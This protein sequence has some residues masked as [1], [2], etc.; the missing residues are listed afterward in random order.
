MDNQTNTILKKDVNYKSKRFLE[1]DFFKGIA[2]IMMVI[3]H[4][5]YLCYFMNIRYYNIN[6]GILNFLAKAAHYT[7]ILVV[8]INL[9][10]INQ[11]YKAAY[12][13]DEYRNIQFG[14]QFKRG[15]FLI[16][17]GMI[18]SILSYL[19]FENM[20]IKFGILHFVGVSVILSQLIVNSKLLTA[21]VLITVLGL[22]YSFKKWKHQLFYKCLSFPM[23][24]FVS[25]VTNVK[26]NSLDHFSIIPYF[27][28]ICLG[29]LFGHILYK[30][31]N[32]RTFINENII[33][34]LKKNKVINV[35]SLLGKNSLF[36][37]F[38]HFIV[39]YFVLSFFKKIN[40]YI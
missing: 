40:N 24:C 23:T 29:I 12:G 13:E 2:V 38:L 18:M 11:K 31:G 9:A 25:G 14:K 37:Y 27:A 28:I 10:V 16:G 8:G 21:L 7:F 30:K 4:F 20:Y 15:M 33:D 6:G 35:I 34:D 39:F 32:T 3:F 1:L 22:N 26:Y 17:A 5:F 19:S 36:I